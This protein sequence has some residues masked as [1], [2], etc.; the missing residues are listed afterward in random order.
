MRCNIPATDGFS[1]GTGSAVISESRCFGRCQP[2]AENTVPVFIRK[3]RIIMNIF[4]CKSFR[5]IFLYQDIWSANCEIY[6]LTVNMV[7]MAVNGINNGRI[8]MIIGIYTVLL[9]RTVRER[10]KG[11]SFPFRKTCRFLHIFRKRWICPYL[12]ENPETKGFM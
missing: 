7:F 3:N 6:L 8:M 11:K 2:Y 1:Y 12:H 4:T 5:T 10:E 9:K